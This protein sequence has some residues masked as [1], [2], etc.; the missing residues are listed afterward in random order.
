MSFK[1]LFFCLLLVSTFS[2]QIMANP[3]KAESETHDEA[4]AR[5]K[6][7]CKSLTPEELALVQARLGQESLKALLGTMAMAKEYK[8]AFETK[9]VKAQ[10]RGKIKDERLH[11]IAD[12]LN[13]YGTVPTLDLRFDAIACGVISQVLGVASS[14]SKGASNKLYGAFWILMGTTYELSG[15]GQSIADSLGYF[16]DGELTAAG[17]KAL[18]ASLAKDIIPE[19]ENLGKVLGWNAS[20]ISKFSDALENK[21]TSKIKLASDGFFDGTKDTLRVILPELEFFELLEKHSPATKEQIEAVKDLR[22]LHQNME[23]IA[24]DGTTPDEIK[25]FISNDSKN[26]ISV[27]RESLMYFGNLLDTI[28]F[29]GDPKV[30][31]KLKEQARFLKFQVESALSSIE[32]VCD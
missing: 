7:P 21:I 2:Q 26:G 16:A 32:L 27:N 13:T 1:G 9:E 15:S 5:A 12:K 29:S 4:G 18:Q 3:P 25:R 10:L 8:E 6:I 17:K 20:Q 30:S 31:D 11:W 14:K 23:K 19:A 24:K 28:S 22:K